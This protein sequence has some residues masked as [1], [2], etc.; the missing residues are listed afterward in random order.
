M[1]RSGALLSLS[2][3][4]HSSLVLA[5]AIRQ[6]AESGDSA[7]LPAMMKRI[8]EHW[9]TVLCEHFAREEHLLR[10]AADAVD[11]ESVDRILAEH[12]ELRSLACG[13]C[14]LDLPARLRRFGELLAA[15]VRYE[16]R[17]LFPQLQS[18]PSIDSAAAE[19][20]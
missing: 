16:E 14:E 9:R 15:H 13:P 11:A 18:H 17:V 1:P 19:S 3:E 8:E 10:L 6:A 5:R 2:R 20:I 7:A 12:A 4:H